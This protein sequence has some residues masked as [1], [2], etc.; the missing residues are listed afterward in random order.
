MPY[1]DS[2]SEVTRPAWSTKRT[3]RTGEAIS[4]TA[5]TMLELSRGNSLSSRW[6]PH[7]KYVMK[8][9]SVTRG[10]MSFV[11]LWVRQPVF[12]LAA[13]RWCWSTCEE[14]WCEADHRGRKKSEADVSCSSRTV[15]LGT[16]LNGT[17]CTRRSRANST[18]EPHTGSWF[19]RTAAV[20]LAS[21]AA[22]CGTGSQIV[23]V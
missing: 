14:I 4:V 17:R 16:M 20:H 23:I 21:G 18:A 5:H 12:G 10:Y 3:L 8:S 6:R 13:R 7:R 11:D 15:A 22:L 1:A 19:F 2:P 9:F